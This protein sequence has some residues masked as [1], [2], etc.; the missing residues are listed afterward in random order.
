[1][2]RFARA[3]ARSACDASVHHKGLSGDEGRLVGGQKVNG[4]GDLIYACQPTQR[5]APS[6]ARLLL[7]RH[8]TDH[9]AV[10]IAGSHRI[11]SDLTWAE[12]A[13]KATRQTVERC[14]GRAIDG[15][16]RMA[17][18]GMH[19]GYVDDAPGALPEHEPRTRLREHESCGEVYFDGPGDVARAHRRQ[20]TFHCNSGIVDEHVD[21]AQPIAHVLH[22]GPQRL[23]IAAVHCAPMEMLALAGTQH[24]GDESCLRPT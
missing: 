12:L 20:N 18:D 1:W 11:D 19:R 22:E 7:L 4:V 14:F 16:A 10:K 5:R 3:S 17:A 21:P 24:I 6:D 9:I 2:I 13:S 8:V 23:V 15:H